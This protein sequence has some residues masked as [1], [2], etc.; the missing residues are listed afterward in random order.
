MPSPPQLIGPMPPA[1]WEASLSRQRQAVL[2]QEVEQIRSAQ[3]EVEK[4]SE[5]FWERRNAWLQRQR[6]PARD[7]Q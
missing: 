1:Q 6:A 5:S 7:A 4:A 2:Q 3:K